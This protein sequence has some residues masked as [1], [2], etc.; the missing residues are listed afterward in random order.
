[1]KERFKSEPREY[2]LTRPINPE[3]LEYSAQD[4]EDLIEI[5]NNSLKVGIELFKKLI[6]NN[7]TNNKNSDK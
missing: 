1:M 2:F 7:H 6:T 3:F 5:F 4:V